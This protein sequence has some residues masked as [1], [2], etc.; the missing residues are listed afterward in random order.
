LERRLVWKYPFD[1]AT[2]LP[3]K[4]SVSVMRRDMVDEEAAP[5]VAA[6]RLIE[7][8]RAASGQLSPAERG[9]AHHAFLQY[10]SLDAVGTRPALETEAQRLVAAGRL[11]EAQVGCL[12]FDALLAFWQSAAGLQWLT[13]KDSIR[14]ELAFTARFAPR[15][16]PGENPETPLTGEF[17]VVQGVIDLCA[18]LP[19][20]IWL[21]DFKT[22]HGTR[23]AL[24]QKT[25]EYRP[26]LELYAQALSRIYRKPVTRIWLYFLSTGLCREFKSDAGGCLTLKE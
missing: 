17:I 1:T 2:R 8:P 25:R 20:D 14:R 5:W 21:L 9:S 23:E 10:V 24:E 18:I 16:P 7:E 26:Q 3:A 13:Q 12:D 15:V 19:E 4:S 11:T 6:H 22:D